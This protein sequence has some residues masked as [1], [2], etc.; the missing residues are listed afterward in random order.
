MD[1][2]NKMTVGLVIELT[3][4]LIQQ[5][6]FFGFLYMFFE[7]PSGK[8]KNI[9][10]F[11]LVVLSMFI[12]ENYFTF[13]EMT[14]NHLDSLIGIIVMILYAV[15]FLKGA[16]YLRIIMPIIIYV[17]NMIVSFSLLYS[18]TYLG[19]KTLEE[20]VA[21]STSFRCIYL[22][23][24]NLTYMLLLWIMLRVSKRKLLLNNIYD[25]LAFIIVPTLCM[26]GMYVDAIVYEIVNFNKLILLLIIINL[27]ILITA[28][29]I[30]WFLLI[31][32]SKD[33][34]VK[35][36]LLLSKQ[37]EELYK[38]SVMATNEQIEKIST[39]KHDVKNNLLSAS[40]LI[41]E[42]QYEKAKLLCDSLCERLTTAHTPVHTGNPVLN[43]IIN[44]E[45]EKS[46]SRNIDFSYDINNDLSF[47]ADS[48]IVSIIGNLCDNAIEYLSKIPESK[49]QMEIAITVYRDY[50]CIT[51]KNTILSSILNIN[52]TLDSTKD[53]VSFHGKGMKIL[54]KIAGK[55]Q[56][57]IICSEEYNQLIVSAIIRSK[58]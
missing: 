4:N 21:F 45:I 24:V 18:I 32:T 51:C 25:I 6:L 50:Y 17:L 46:E 31:K 38:N 44:V 11:S 49:R 37:R 36:D 34:K 14:F 26:I 19:G 52:P 7:K 35:T 29:V 15:L 43:A 5:I 40:M 55:Y 13:Y 48:D 58:N 54:N 33:N 12:I 10:I 42:G 3:F 9:I 53:D 56:G 16:L 39:I 30:V 20:S 1:G 57:E 2:E 23:I 47:V 41:T 28:S 8:T 22:V 27:L